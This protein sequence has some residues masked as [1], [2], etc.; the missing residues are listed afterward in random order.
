MLLEK[1]TLSVEELDSQVAVE[2]PE[3]D[4][5]ALINIFII[6]LVDGGILN[7]LNIEVKNNNV[8]V[9]VCAVVNALSNTGD[10]DLL[11]T[12]QQ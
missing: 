4:M 3:R 9:Q 6:D 7:N 11:C 12:V 2:L 1:K 5:M 10:V 8:A